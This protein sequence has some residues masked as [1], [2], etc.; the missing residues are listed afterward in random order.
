MTLRSG[1]SSRVTFRT[2]SP[3]GS[4]ITAPHLF[5]RESARK[6][7][8]TSLVGLRPSRRQP[9]R[10][11]GMT[12]TATTGRVLCVRRSTHTTTHGRGR[13]LRTI[14]S[15]FSSSTRVRSTSS[16]ERSN[17]VLCGRPCGRRG[18]LNA[19]RWSRGRPHMI[20]DSRLDRCGR[21]RRR[22]GVLHS[23]G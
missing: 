2:L 5:L 21:D 4:L 1:D 11:V 22:E 20:Y 19:A 3:M 6:R 14:A 16:G 23:A 8:K 10:T 13:S 18:R 7:A 12:L 15:G 17:R 9:A